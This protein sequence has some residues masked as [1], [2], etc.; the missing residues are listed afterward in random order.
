M[1]DFW[2][3]YVFHIVIV[4][5]F[6]YQLLGVK[7]NY[8]NKVLIY[9]LII[10]IFITI[11]SLIDTTEI[12]LGNVCILV[13][14]IV[15]SLF[16]IA[17]LFQT[18]ICTFVAHIIIIMINDIMINL[19]VSIMNTTTLQIYYDTKGHIIVVVICF[20]TDLL[21]LM[22]FRYFNLVLFDGDDIISSDVINNQAKNRNILFNRYN[23]VVLAIVIQMGLLTIYFQ[24]NDSTLFYLSSEVHSVKQNYPTLITS[25]AIIVINIIVIFMIKKI[26][27]SEREQYQNKLNEVKYVQIHQ[28]E[29]INRQ[30]RHDLANHFRVLNILLKEEKYEEMNN[31]FINYYQEYYSN[32]ILVNTGLEELD[33]LI[34]SKISIAQKKNIIVKYNCTAEITCEKRHII[35]LN[36][37]IGNVLDNAIEASEKSEKRLF[38]IKINESTFD[39]IFTIE[40]TTNFTEPIKSE[41]LL[42]EG[43]STKGSGRGI[44]LS[45]VERLVKKYSGRFKITSDNNNFVITIN[46]PKYELTR[47]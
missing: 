17:D 22:F 15:L 12:M 19:I 3:Y 14:V 36:S 39:Y 18:F 32:S 35:N 23:Q 1:L 28:Q 16:R 21:L 8:L 46:L 10:A 13:I 6:V 45:V 33:I 5:Y 40:N 20:L 31:Y 30:Y 2:S 25:L 42:K 38:A 4:I 29:N 24:I 47:D 9:L 26:L 27:I 7:V 43:Y 37:I 41:I 34:N 44:G 11:T